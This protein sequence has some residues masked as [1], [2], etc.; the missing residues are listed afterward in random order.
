MIVDISTSPRAAEYPIPRV[1]YAEVSRASSSPSVSWGQL[2]MPSTGTTPQSSW[3]GINSVVLSNGQKVHVVSTS[4]VSLDVIENAGT[5]PERLNQIKS[6]LDL[7]ITQMADLFSVT[8]KSVYDWYEGVEPRQ[9]KTSRMET[10]I[11]VLIEASPA[12]DLSRLK[13]VWSIPVNGRSFLEIFNDD[14]LDATS[15]KVALI[16]TLHELSPRMAKTIS[17][18]NKAALQF[19][20]SHL[21]DIDRVADFT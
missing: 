1:L 4:A 19:G 14:K 7:S 17:S 21:V 20:S 3:Y 5:L 11:D 12:L 13:V 16:T 8:R 9:L 6:R 15:L 10:L 2:F 18:T